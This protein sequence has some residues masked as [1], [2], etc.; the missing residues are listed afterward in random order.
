MIYKLLYVQCKIRIKYI[1]LWQERDSSKVPLWC[2]LHNNDC[3]KLYAIFIGNDYTII[4]CEIDSA[5][6]VRYARGRWPAVTYRSII[7]CVYTT[8]SEFNIIYIITNIITLYTQIKG[9]EALVHAVRT[10]DTC[11]AK[12]FDES[13]NSDT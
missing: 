1:R 7:F 4:L 6:I 8:Y 5:N 3:Q 10:S 9:I 12:L 11:M 13:C 2:R